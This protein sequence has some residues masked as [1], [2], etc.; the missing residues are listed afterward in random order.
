MISW[1]QCPT[2]TATPINLVAEESKLN[3]ATS[4]DR[5][6]VNFEKQIRPFDREII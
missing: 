4:S 1:S 5:Y 3:N 6:D 2:K